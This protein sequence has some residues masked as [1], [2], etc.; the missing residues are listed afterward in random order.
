MFKKIDELLFRR[1]DKVLQEFANAADVESLVKILEGLPH[2]RKKMFGLL[3]PERAA[4]VLRGLSPYVRQYVLKDLGAS[5]VLAVMNFLESDEIA[6][7]IKILPMPTRDAVIA[8]LKQYDPKKVLE[9][10]RLPEETAGGLMK[11]EI[12]VGK[13][14]DTVTEF[15]T[16]LKATYPKTVPKTSYIYIVDDHGKLLG[17]VNFNRLYLADPQ[18]KLSDLMHSTKNPVYVDEDQEAVAS[19]FTTQDAL[20]LPVVDKT[21]ALVGRISADDI[22]DVLR[23]EFSEDITRLVGATPN[24]RATDPYSVKVKRR[25]PWLVIN[26][27]TAILAALVVSLF[28]DTIGRFVILAAFM[29]II[30]GMGGNAATQTLGVTVRAIAL[31]EINQFNTWRVIFKEVFTGMTNGMATGVIMGLIAFLYTQNLTL[32]LVIFVA[33]TFNLFIAGLGGAV[34]PLVMRGLGFDPALASTVFVT[35]LTDVCGFFAFLGLAT[36]LL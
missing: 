23:T 16:K 31:D 8:E 32:G 11:T 30:A 28:T 15:I 22:I 35:T 29:P 17:A 33:M 5:K 20:E 12:V 2:G 27:V 34:I 6:D 26:L 9:L 4:K 1:E 10:A 19:S 7:L 18:G 13:P 24:E 21:G 36:L 14:K 3:H 25:L